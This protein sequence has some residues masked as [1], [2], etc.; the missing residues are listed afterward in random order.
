MVAAE[1]YE[2]SCIG[3][4]LHVLRLS[5]VVFVEERNTIPG[6]QGMLPRAHFHHLGSWSEG[7]V[8]A[9]VSRLERKD[10]A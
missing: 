6:G 3:V 9:L 4:K 5:E 7:T 2:G 10:F 8:A 1:T